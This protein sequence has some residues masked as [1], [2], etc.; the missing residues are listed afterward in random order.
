MGTRLHQLHW[1]CYARAM[2]DHTRS[3]L[4]VGAKMSLCDRRKCNA[5]AR[6]NDCVPFAGYKAV[7]NG[8]VLE[9]VGSFALDLSKCERLTLVVSLAGNTYCFAHFLFALCA[10]L[11]I[12]SYRDRIVV[13]RERVNPTRGYGFA[14]KSLP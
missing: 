7:A 4:S 1:Q 12:G 11:L 14:G 8:N 13:L 6:L 3:T 10:L 2:V 5:C 9:F